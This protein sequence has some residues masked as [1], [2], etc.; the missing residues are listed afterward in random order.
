MKISKTAK[1]SAADVV[2]TKKAAP[3]AKKTVKAAAPAKKEVTFTVHAEKGKAVY[4]AGEFNNW[5]PTAKKMV[6]KCKEGIYSASLKLDAGTYQYKFVI[7]GIWCCDPENEAT[8]GND[9]GT[10]NSVVVVK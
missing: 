2:V 3:A 1:K 9:Q 7:D 10:F 5:N 4:V 6:Y 8:V